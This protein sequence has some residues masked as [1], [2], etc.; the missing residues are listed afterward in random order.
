[1]A[2]KVINS[3][4]W[5]VAVEYEVKFGVVTPQNRSLEMGDG[6]SLSWWYVG[7]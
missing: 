7:R 6:D 4:E 2:I 3:P 5:G 1:M